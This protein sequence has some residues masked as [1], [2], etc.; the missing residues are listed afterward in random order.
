MKKILIIFI[1]L[2][3]VLYSN[4]SSA[5]Q[6][7]HGSFGISAAFNGTQGDILIPIWLNNNNSLA[8]AIGVVNIGKSYTDLSIALVYHHYFPYSESFSPLLGFRGGALLGLPD[9]GTGTTDYLFGL[10]GGG[11]YFF[12][13]NFSIGIEAQLNFSF[14]DKR[15]ARFGNPGGTTINTGSVIFAAV[16]F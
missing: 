12:S 10:A 16:Y 3:S 1:T 9:P 5:Q 4:I 13:P 6:L 7:S 14:S 15:S 8:P 2:F 11:E